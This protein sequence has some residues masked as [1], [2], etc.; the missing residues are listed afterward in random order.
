MTPKDPLV[1]EVHVMTDRDMFGTLARCDCF[2]DLCSSVAT[3]TRD[4]SGGQR[5]PVRYCAACAAAWDAWQA[6]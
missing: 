4:T 2:S 1:D 5:A 6:R 3:T